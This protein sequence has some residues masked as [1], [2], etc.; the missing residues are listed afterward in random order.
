ML[1]LSTLLELWY[2][3]VACV[4][5]ISLESLQIHIN[6]QMQKRHT[7]YN[8]TCN[9]LAGLIDISEYINYNMA[10]RRVLMVVWMTLF[11]F[12]RTHSMNWMAAKKPKMWRDWRRLDVG[13]FHLAG[14]RMKEVKKE[15]DF[16]VYVELTWAQTHA[17]YSRLT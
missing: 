1:F 17:N 13:A 16:R 2:R 11:K 5:L 7:V 15:T 14:E 10:K 9:K 12:L 4:Y 8:F 6:L 3:F